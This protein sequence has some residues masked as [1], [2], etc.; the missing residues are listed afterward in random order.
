MND[1]FWVLGKTIYDVSTITHIQFIIN[2]PKLFGLTKEEIQAI[3][4]KYN[5]KIPVER[6][7]RE[8]IIKKVSEKGFIRVRHYSKPDYWSIQ[9][10]DYR[11]RK[12]T[13][14]EFL[15][16]AIF[17]KNIMTKFSELILV[18]FKDNYHKKYDFYSGGA[19]SYFDEHIN[20]SNDFKYYIWDELPENFLNN[21]L[22]AKDYINKIKDKI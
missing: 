6:K 13:I 19:L 21:E 14:T 7:A 4:K 3:Y 10:D 11:K 18:G 5:E 9:F 2:K 16:W 12:K 8:E 15:S 17:D 22:F 20:I 1:A